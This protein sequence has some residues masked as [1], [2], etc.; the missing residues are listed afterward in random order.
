MNT[1]FEAGIP[2]CWAR[3]GA[4]MLPTQSA[5]SL[6]TR[7]LFTVMS[8]K[9]ILGNL[10]ATP[11]VSLVGK[12]ALMRKKQNSLIISLLPANRAGRVSDGAT[13]PR[14]VRHPDPDEAPQPCTTLFAIKM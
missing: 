13:P 1:V 8:S 12:I 2:S 10:V 5:A 7:E 14:P 11:R 9:E 6:V 4:R 3:A